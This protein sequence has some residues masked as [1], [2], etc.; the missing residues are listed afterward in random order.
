MHGV[1]A[2]GFGLIRFA[3]VFMLFQGDRFAAPHLALCFFGL[4]FAI[5]IGTVWEIFEFAMDEIFGMNMQ[6][7]GLRDTMGDLIVNFAGA[8]FG[9][10]IGYLYL[11]GRERAFLTSLI[12]EF[13]E[14]NPKFFGKARPRNP[15]DRM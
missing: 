10:A 14:R 13:V 3:A 4:C 12:A 15:T 7:S 8:L 5:S 1:S 6:K 9:S 2:I 11:I